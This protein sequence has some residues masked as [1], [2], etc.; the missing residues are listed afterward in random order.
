MKAAVL[1]ISDGVARGERAAERGALL[2]E[3]LTADGYEV[4][5]RVVADERSEIAEA[6]EELSDESPLV[7][8]TGPP[9][10]PW[11]VAASNTTSVFVTSPMWPWVVEGR[12][13]PR[14]PRFASIRSELV[15]LW[16][17]ISLTIAPSALA[18]SASMPAG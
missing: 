1:T 15:P 6:I 8:T 4:V 16:L 7:L 13:R 10:P 2:A 14:R 12:I 18:R 11:V 5:R 3:L 9:L 17:T